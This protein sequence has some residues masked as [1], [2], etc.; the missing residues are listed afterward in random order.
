VAE[1]FLLSIHHFNQGELKYVWPFYLPSTSTAASS[2]LEPT[3]TS[4]LTGLREGTVL[5]SC[6]GTMVKPSSLKHVPLD[7]FADGEGKPFTLGPQTAASYLSLK[8][9]I[10]ATKATCAI[11]V[12]ELSPQ[13]FLQDLS[14]AV[15]HDPITFRTRLATWHSQLAK[16]LITLEP[17]RNFCP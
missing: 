7:P 9:P 1:A 13:E 3:I 4:I 15:I 6:A 17:R 2:F 5:E 8:Y 14:S 10:C 16:T 12:S 11:G